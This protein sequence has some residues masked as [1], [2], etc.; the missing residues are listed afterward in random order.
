MITKPNQIIIFAVNIY[1]DY[2]WIFSD[3]Q[4]LFWAFQI[5]SKIYKVYKYRARL[6]LGLD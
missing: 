2:I 4:T 1:D 3:S 6:G 5:L